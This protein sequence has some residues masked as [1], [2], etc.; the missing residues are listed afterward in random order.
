MPQKTFCLRH[1]FCKFSG[2]AA[3]SSSE[4]TSI[5]I[6]LNYFLHSLLTPFP[7]ENF[8]PVGPAGTVDRLPKGTK[9]S[10]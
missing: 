8:K 6:K 5:V 7:A 1:D 4:W 9:R 3:A 2:L 10:P